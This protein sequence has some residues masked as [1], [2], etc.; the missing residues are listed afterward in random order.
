M[1]TTRDWK[2]RDGGECRG[3]VRRGGEIGNMV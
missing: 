2:A 1:L 3:G